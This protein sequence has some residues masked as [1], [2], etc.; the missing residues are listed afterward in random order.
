VVVN[1]DVSQRTET[2]RDKVRRTD[3]AVEKTASAPGQ[4]AEVDSFA[5][6]LATSPRCRGRDWRAIESDARQNF[7]RQYPGRPWDQVK[8]A[9]HRTYD[10]V[11]QNA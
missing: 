5:K 7:E 11:H 1:K 4:S 10:R 8:D 9:I 2:V 6:E 3:V